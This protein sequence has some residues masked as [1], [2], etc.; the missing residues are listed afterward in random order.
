MIQWYR[1]ADELEYA[2]CVGEDPDGSAGIDLLIGAVD[3]VG[4]GIG[5]I[6]LRAFVD[7]IVFA[8]PTITLAMAGPH[9]ENIRSVRAFEKAGFSFRRTV[10]IPEHGPE[11]DHGQAARRNG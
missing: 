8:D 1:L 7:Q 10:M 11:L 5:A 4:R 3:A 2:T 6:V 9:P